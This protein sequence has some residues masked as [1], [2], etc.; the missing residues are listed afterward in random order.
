[1]AKKRH[2]SPSRERYE[3]THPVISVR[4]PKKWVDELDAYLDEQE[5]SRGDFFRT[6]FGKQKANLQITHS[7]GYYK[8]YN[9]GYNAGYE[10]GKQDCGVQFPCNKCGELIYL[11]LHSNCHQAIIGFLKEHGWNHV[12]CNG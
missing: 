5:L 6:S 8:G 12:E 1:M 9:I 10:K 4:M 7:Q 2:R 3:K 11:P